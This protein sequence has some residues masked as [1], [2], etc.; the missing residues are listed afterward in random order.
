MI[1]FIQRSQQV[2]PLYKLPEMILSVT[3]GRNAHPTSVVVGRK[4]TLRIISPYHQALFLAITPRRVQAFACG[5]QIL[6]CSR[7]CR[8]GFV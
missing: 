7:L 6:L 2:C 8:F 5:F 3:V 1:L 4:F